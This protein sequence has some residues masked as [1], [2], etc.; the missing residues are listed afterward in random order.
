MSFYLLFQVSEQV[1]D[2]E[3]KHTHGYTYPDMTKT[4]GGFQLN[5]EVRGLAVLI[6][7]QHA[8]SVME[9]RV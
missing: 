4:M 6:A 5:I 2:E 7:G 8:I 9:Y 3:I 1:D